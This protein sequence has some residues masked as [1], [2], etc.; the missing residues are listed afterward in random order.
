[1][2]HYYSVKDIERRPAGAAYSPAMGNWVT[3]ERI[4]FGEIRIPA[5]TGSKPHRHPNEQFIIVLEGSVR[6]D[7]EGDAKTLS[8]GDI[9]HIPPNA[10]HWAEVVGDEEFVFVTAKDTSWGIEGTAEEAESK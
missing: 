10:L 6:M 5:G 7:I 3:G 9:I 1:V 8:P 2:Q 4:I